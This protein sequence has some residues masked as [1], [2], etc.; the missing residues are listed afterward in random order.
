MEG[1]IF[2]RTSILVYVQPKLHL[3]KCFALIN[4]AISFSRHIQYPNSQFY[5]S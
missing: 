2:M 1:E 4:A 5:P 3:T